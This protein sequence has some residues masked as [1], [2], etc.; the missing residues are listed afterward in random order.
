MKILIQNCTSHLF[1]AKGWR[2]TDELNGALTFENT[3]KALD[4]CIASQDENLQNVLK[5]DL[6]VLDVALPLNRAA[7]A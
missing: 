7:C 5:F 3:T 6:P 1:L 4:V 2:W